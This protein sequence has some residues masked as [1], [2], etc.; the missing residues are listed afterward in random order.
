[1]TQQELHNPIKDIFCLI[2]KTYIFQSK[3]ETF[4]K[5]KKKRN[6]IGISIF[7]YENKNQYPVYV[8]KQ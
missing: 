4:T 3:L 5:S 7:G 1:M 8:S 2:L 6:F